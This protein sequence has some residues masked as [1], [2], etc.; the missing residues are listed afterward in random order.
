MQH[1]RDPLGGSQCLE[2]H[3]QPETDGVTQEGFV[4]GVDPVLTTHD[5]IG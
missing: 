5:G 1:E 4:L 2:Y 3:E